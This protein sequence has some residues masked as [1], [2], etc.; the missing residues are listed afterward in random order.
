[1]TLESKQNYVL[2]N[3]LEY[4]FKHKH[5]FNNTQCKI[6]NRHMLYHRS[7][8]SMWFI[9]ENTGLYSTNK[10]PSE[11]HSM[12]NNVTSVI[13]VFTSSAW[14][15]SHKPDSSFVVLNEFLDKGKRI[16]LYLEV[17]FHYL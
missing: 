6:H 7:H 12:H 5:L 14:I 9:E 1:M 17:L 13:T 10:W 8:L 2:I 3:D 11:M 4:I 15:A 16:D